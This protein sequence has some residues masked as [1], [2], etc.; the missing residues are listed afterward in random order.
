M[1]APKNILFIMFDQL[2]WDYLS[3]YGHPHLHTPN[4]DRLAA[5][6]T[7]F[8]RCDASA[9]IT[10]P[11][12]ATILTG[13]FPPRHGVRDNGIFVLEPRFE[14]LAERLRAAGYRVQE[15]GNSECAKLDGGMSCLSLRF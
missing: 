9:P 11:S 2:R 15:I 14:T 12:H 5:G 10:L 3:C 1:P 4:L 6:G 8:E 7:R 13:L